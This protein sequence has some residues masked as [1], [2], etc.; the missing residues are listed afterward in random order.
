[1]KIQKIIKVMWKIKNESNFLKPRGAPTATSPRWPLEVVSQSGAA[2]GPLG[3]GLTLG[4]AIP[5]HCQ[6][7]C[8][9]SNG[10]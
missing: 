9:F 8:H 7:C 10:S 4:V 5:T 2:A 1:M 6:R 3:C